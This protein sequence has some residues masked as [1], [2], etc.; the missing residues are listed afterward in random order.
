MTG[1]RNGLMCLRIDGLVFCRTTLTGAR[2]SACALPPVHSPSCRLKPQDCRRG[3]FYKTNARASLGKARQNGSHLRPNGLLASEDG[4]VL[5]GR[6]HVNDL[7]ARLPLVLVDLVVGV[8]L[9]VK[10]GWASL[11][12]NGDVLEQTQSRGARKPNDDAASARHRC[13]IAHQIANLLGGA[14]PKPHR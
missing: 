8:S 1:M 12:N 14:S 5:V 7:V 6:D 11:G 13:L 2:Y 10:D 4:A 3:C 9:F